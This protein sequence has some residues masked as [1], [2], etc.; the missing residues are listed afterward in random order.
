MEEL[1][2]HIKAEGVF[3]MDSAILKRKTKS[4]SSLFKFVY[5]IYY[6]VF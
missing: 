5:L 3:G 1:R 6:I 2:L 4:P